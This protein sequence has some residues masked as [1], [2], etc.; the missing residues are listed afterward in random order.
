[1]RAKQLQQGPPQDAQD[2]RLTRLTLNNS[3]GVCH[4]CLPNPPLPPRTSPAP[5]LVV[6]GT[7][8]PYV[9]SYFS[10]TS[11]WKAV[12]F[13]YDDIGNPGVASEDG[14]AVGEEDDWV[15]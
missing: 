12:M 1:M 15:S 5:V 6:S 4:T 7:S 8:S 3:V 13:G 10:A 2:H 11:S 9:W 14:V